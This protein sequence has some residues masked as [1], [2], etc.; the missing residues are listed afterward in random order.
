MSRVGGCVVNMAVPGETIA[1]RGVGIAIARMIDGEMQGY[2]GI[3]THH[4]C[5]VVIGCGRVRIIDAV[6]CELV[7]GLCRCVA[8]R[9]LVYCQ[10]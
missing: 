3:A 2:K 5:A 4:I 9:G 10:V 8:C 1:Y 7:A 6:P